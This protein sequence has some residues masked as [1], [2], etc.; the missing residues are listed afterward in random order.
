MMR[1]L[2]CGCYIESDINRD[3]VR[4]GKNYAE[5]GFLKKNKDRGGRYD[6]LI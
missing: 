4:E 3:S 1:L 2:K 6:Y 5:M